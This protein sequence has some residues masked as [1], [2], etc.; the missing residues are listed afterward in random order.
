[1]KKKSTL[2]PELRELAGQV[3]RLQQRA[4]ELGLFDNS[5]ELLTCPQCGLAE[6]V[7]I[8]GLLVVTKPQYRGLDTG[9][10]FKEQRGGRFQ[11][12]LCGVA[13]AAPEEAA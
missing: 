4:R 13:F 7:T 10:R 9:L 2:S 5:R 11:C 6:D 12:P 1:M 3:Q 8:E